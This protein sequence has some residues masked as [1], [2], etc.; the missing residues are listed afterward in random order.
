M[1]FFLFLFSFF[2]FYPPAVLARSRPSRRM[3]RARKKKR[4]KFVES[5]ALYP[6]SLILSKDCIPLVAL[7]CRKVHGHLDRRTWNYESIRL[8]ASQPVHLPDSCPLLQSQR[9]YPPPSLCLCAQT[10]ATFIFSVRLRPSAP[11]AEGLI[12]RPNHH[13]V[14]SSET[15]GACRPPSTHS[16]TSLNSP[17]INPVMS[18]DK[19]HAGLRHPSLR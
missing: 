8:R 11:E 4:E 10:S 18:T 7:P 16:H 6:L 9:T 14:F 15:S 1:I 19:M 12:D 5:T 13:S 3:G 17:C 2:L